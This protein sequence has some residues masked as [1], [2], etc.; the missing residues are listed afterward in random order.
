LDATAITQPATFCIEYALA[1]LW[2]SRGLQ[3]AAMIG[4]S[5]G[6]FV[7]AVMA[8]VM[9]LD[10]AARL[11]ARRGK[12]MNAL[13]RGAM[14][15]VRL[16]ANALRT[17]IPASLS[18][19]AENG[20]QSCVLSGPLEDIEACAIAL[21]SDGVAC[22]RLRTSHAFHSSMMDPMIAAFEREVQSIK[23]STPKLPIISTVTGRELTA[24]EAV[25]PQ[26]WARH[27]RE[28]VEFSKAVR[29]ALGRE[30][31]VFLEV[32]MH[33]GL[34]SLIQQH[35]ALLSDPKEIVV[36]GSLA[37]DV[38]AERTAFTSAVG[39]LWTL[40]INADAQSGSARRRVL[41][42][43]YS[44]DY[45]RCWLD[46]LPATEKLARL[47]TPMIASNG[48]NGL[49]P[50]AA[51]AAAAVPVATVP[52]STVPA[53]TMPVATVP[54]TTAPVVLARAAD[55]RASLLL[56]LRTL[57][58]EIA[59][60]DLDDAPTS[61]AFVE[62]GLDSLVLTQVAI[63]VK[64]RFKV[65][66]TFRQL[67]EQYNSLDEL[68]GFLDATLPVEKVGILVAGPVV[69]ASPAA[70]STI[71]GV[72]PAESL[73]TA[74]L[75][76]TSDGATTAFT[77][78]VV[79]QQLQLMAQQLALLG[80]GSTGDAPAAPIA[81]VPVANSPAII[82]T[83]ETAAGVTASAQNGRVP[84]PTLDPSATD[85]E[86]AQLAHT[87]YDV[88][89]AFGA[90][91]RIHTRAHTELTAR[92]RLRLEAFIRRY[93]A[94]TAASKAYT[95]AHRGHLADPR[96]VNGFRP[97]TKEISYQLVVNRSRGS[98]V[99]DLDGNEYVDAL[100]GFGMNLFGWQPSFV[101]E[102]VKHQLEEGHEIGPQHPLAGEVADLMCELTGFDRAGL[103]NTGSEAVLG[104]I[105]IARTVTGRNL[106]VIF[107]GSYHG[108][109]D[110]VLVRGTRTQRAV[111]AAPGILQA[112]AENVLVLDYGTEASLE[113]IRQRADEI[114]A[115][116]VEPVQSRRPDF[117]PVEF[118]RDVR[119]I[120]EENGTVLIFDE[121]IT[122]FRADTRGAQA[123]FD[124]RADLAAYGKVIG[125][126]YPIGV[127]AGKREFMDALDG[128]A[129]EFG[130]DSVPTVGVTYF[131][132]TFVRHPLALAACKAVLM[133]LRDAGP[134]LQHT[135]TNTTTQM[136]DLMNAAARAVDAPVEVRQFASLWRIAFIEEHPLQD[137]LWAMMRDR[138]IHILD[139]F[140]CF[141][142][143]AHSDT[144]IALI[145]RAFRES[146][147]EMQA[148]EFFPPAPEVARVVVAA[149]QPPVPNARLGRDK[150]GSPAWF[151]PDPETP[152]QYVRVRA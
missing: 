81:N 142:T 44:F 128:G 32:G 48:S 133:H 149:N 4:H 37:A 83:L 6:E 75:P 143:T 27:A 29:A 39:H 17:R 14:L 46:A 137:L 138:G 115:V 151:V 30:L 26:Y 94:R 7:A 101:T 67:N 45:I 36:I 125:G 134:A 16:D 54:V 33:S 69:L 64:R 131:A 123:L 10:D 122:G 23:L 25:A 62:L 55:R 136:V 63:Q 90:I 96:V 24:E 22:R 28:P 68:V 85:S 95:V 126:G 86:A 141:L 145:V 111:P 47:T 61:A 118:L 50:H 104:T 139:N 41:L 1:E 71:T 34:T 121:V 59:G 147:A 116:L 77:K 73:F 102:A 152:G 110:E 107:T 117:R 3:A 146:L 144:D 127:I 135:L 57:V 150:D 119:R 15:S 38:G 53:G 80:G 89:K 99:W 70:N 76:N 19:S 91:A 72:L 56:A 97:Q 148:S 98:R 18:L 108:I 20:P 51:L 124:I 132:G 5:I 140:P 42:P 74:S 113:I 8:G 88:K 120:T 2:R 49:V 13:P 103:C 100:N 21:E 129:W 114:A 11:V 112:A 130:D 66:L 78:E 58:G 40:G 31:R 109:F 93:A 9:S 92:Q 65:N 106:I 105:R 60:V 52:V 12:L 35:A 87:R 82:S 84:T 79:R 43:T